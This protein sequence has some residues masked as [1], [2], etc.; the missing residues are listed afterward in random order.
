MKHRLPRRAL[1]LGTAAGLV[2]TGCTA[3]DG[4]SADTVKIGLIVPQT[5]VYEEVGNDMRAGFELYLET[6]NNELGGRKVELLVG[7]EG[8]GP[9]T[10][11][12]VASRF[13]QQDEVVAL[14]GIASGASYA[15]ISVFAQEQGVPLIGSGGRPTLDPDQLEGLWHTSWISE[16][17]GTAIAPYMAENLDGPVYAIGPDYQGGHDQ[18]RGFTENFLEAG[19]TLANPTGETTWTKFP[20]TD[21]FLPYF[22]EIAQTDAAAIYTFYAGAAAVNFVQQWAQSDAKDIPLYG[23]F[24]TEGSALTAQGDAAEGVYTVMNYSADLD[25]AANRE[26]VSEW[27]AAGLTGQPSLYAMCSW[28]AASVLDQAIASIPAG[29]EVTSEAIN[30]A[31][32][33]LGEIDSPR[34]PWRFSDTHAPVQRWYLR[35]V[36]LDGQQ[37]SN[38]VIQ[39]LATLGD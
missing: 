31:V 2:L 27:T 10:S 7:D 3:D 4:A 22:T 26:F 1:L 19:G 17:N 11:Y 33:E 18:L 25:N 16:E 23:A 39:E 30:A 5:G 13:V 38:V 37:L 28:D 12:D 36:Q 20:D 8:D 15:E 9:A 29:E 6:H 32:A 14:T 21:N 24:L 34:G 35:Q